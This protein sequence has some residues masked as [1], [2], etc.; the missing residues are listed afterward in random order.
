MKFIYVN[1][2]ELEI[3]YNTNIKCGIQNLNVNKGVQSVYL[4][5]YSDN[6][7]TCFSNYRHKSVHVKKVFYFKLSSYKFREIYLYNQ[8]R[9]MCYMNNEC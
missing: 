4:V 2:Y 1:Y 7:I 3:E 6:C 8:I 5:Q 9:L